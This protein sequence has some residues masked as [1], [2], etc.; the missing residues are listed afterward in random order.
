MSGSRAALISVAVLLFA[1]SAGR[2]QDGQQ[3]GGGRGMMGGDPNQMFDRL[4][5]G[6]DVI[7][8]TD[9][10][11]PRM[12]RMFDRMAEGLGITNGQVTREQF[13]TFMQQRMA[14]RG[15][16]GGPGQPGGGGGAPGAGGNVDAWAENS[17]RRL[18]QNGD[19]YLNNDE[20]PEDLRAER[21]RWDTDHNGLIDLNEF[22]AYFQARMQQRMAERGGGAGAGQPIVLTAPDPVEEEKRPVVYHTGKLPKE[23]PAWF[24]Q[25][26]TNG[27]A[28]VSLYEWKAAGRPIDE[29]IKMDRNGDGFLTVQEVLAY[30]A[31]QSKGGPPQLAGGTSGPSRGPDGGDRPGRNG[32]GRRGFAG[33]VGNGGAG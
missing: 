22:K 13:T 28:Q 11:D 5:N 30:Q 27:D 23:L 10:A 2:A 16:G 20:M 9:I 31:K 4:A 8:R 33:R 29:F 32:G 17:F 18:D 3:G 26:D 21:E 12:Q 25:L 14:R 19:G 24:Q 6:S 7:R 1:A 15:G